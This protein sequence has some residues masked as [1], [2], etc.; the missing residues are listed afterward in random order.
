MES[1]Q[2]A[3]MSFITNKM[4]KELRKEL[5]LKVERFVKGNCFICKQPC[6]SESYAHYSCSLAYEDERIKRL[7]EALKDK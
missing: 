1:A 3:Q 5:I 7:K 6:E 2:N 4:K